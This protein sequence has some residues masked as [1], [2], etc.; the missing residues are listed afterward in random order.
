VDC[1]NTS[2]SHETNQPQRRPLE[3]EEITEL[4]GRVRVS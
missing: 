3:A 4:K 2:S 1:L